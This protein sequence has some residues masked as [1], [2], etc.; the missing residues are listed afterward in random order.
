M[1]ISKAIKQ[2]FVGLAFLA[3]GS[4]SWAQSNGAVKIE[5]PF[6]FKCTTE[7]PSTSF[8]FADDGD[9]FNVRVLHHNGTQYAP[10][11]QRLIV[12]NDMASLLDK[13]EV[14]K[15]TG[16]DI[17]LRWDKKNCKRLNDEIFSCVGGGESL[18]SAKKEIKPWLISRSE[19]ITK[20]AS[21]EFKKYTVTLSYE[22]Q[23]QSYDYVMDYAPHEC[24]FEEEI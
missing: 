16:S 24:R 14:A 5:R 1:M 21:G 3:F 10:F 18:T 11:I 9:H 12:P 19:V 8:W 2:V 6:D 23:G 22:I 4:S 7:F 13:A 17:M 15:N 20:T